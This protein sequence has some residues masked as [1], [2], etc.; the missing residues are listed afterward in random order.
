MVSIIIRVSVTKILNDTVTK[1]NTLVWQ[2]VTANLE[3]MIPIRRR[4]HPG[5]R[6]LAAVLTAVSKRGIDV[7]PA[8][9]DM[10]K[11]G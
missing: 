9:D 4:E 5:N 6:L 10:F 11:W 7:R 8:I 2:Y 1:S 3:P